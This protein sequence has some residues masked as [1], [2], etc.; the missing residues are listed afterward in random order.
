[1]LDR[2]TWPSASRSGRASQDVNAFKE[3]STLALAREYLERGWS[4]VPQKAGE[5]HP[6]VRWKEF[7]QRLPTDSELAL[8]FGTTWPDAGMAV[9]LGRV[10]NLLVIDV[11][12]EEAHQALLA[13]LGAEP[14]APKTLSGSGQPFRY[15]LFFRHPTGVTTKAKYTPWHPKLE[16]RGERGVVILPPSRHPSGKCYQ[17]VPGRSPADLD[18]AGVPTAVYDA[19]NQ[20]TKEKPVETSDPL[21]ATA[22]T[23]ALDPARAYVMK[24]PPAVEGQNGDKH[25][26]TLACTLVRRFHLA[27]DDALRLMQDWNQQCQPPWTD[28]QL[29]HKIEAADEI[30]GPRGQLL[31][32]LSTVDSTD[33]DPLGNALPA[34]QGLPDFRMIDQ[35]R[36]QLFATIAGL[37]RPF[38]SFSSWPKLRDIQDAKKYQEQAFAEAMKAIADHPG[39]VLA[40]H[41]QQGHWAMLVRNRADLE[42][43]DASGDSVLSFDVLGIPWEGSRWLLGPEANR[44]HAPCTWE[45]DTGIPEEQIVTGLGNIASKLRLRSAAG[46]LWYIHAQVIHQNCNLTWLPDVS[47]ASVVWGAEPKPA[48]WRTVLH[49][50]LVSLTLLRC[51]TCKAN[52]MLQGVPI[53]NNG[54]VL[55][56]EVTDKRERHAECPKACPLYQKNCPHHH[57]VVKAGN[58]FL[59]QLQLFATGNN[60]DGSVSFDFNPSIRAAVASYREV[61]ARH[62]DEDSREFKSSLKSEAAEIKAHHKK[63]FRGIVT[64]PVCI[65]ALGPS[66]GLSG[67]QCQIL[68]ALVRETT[69]ARRK[70]ERPDN[71]DVFSGKHV[72]GTGNGKS[73]ECVLLDPD[74]TYVGFNGN[75]L[76]HGQGY[77]LLTWMTRCGYSV[78]REGKSRRKSIRRFLADLASMPPEFGLVVAGLLKGKWFALPA[79]QSLAETAHGMKALGDMTL[80][81]YAPA[82]YHHQWRAWVA[83]QLSP[84]VPAPRT[85]SGFEIKPA[86]KAAR[87]TQDDLA[88][89]LGKKRTY[90]N[91]LL[92]GKKPWS[93]DLLSSASSYL[94]DPL[95]ILPEM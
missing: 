75:K 86:L 47:L 50:Q 35:S 80:R 56:R 24:V 93:A 22:V 90:I 10:S 42:T 67:S 71:A 23:K 70:G 28:D 14:E 4:I 1:M 92:N 64:A 20:R 53:C 43:T 95:A 84:S 49:R 37:R 77:R 82:T 61:L 33:E 74:G 60:P 26:F 65:Q 2:N 66:A 91:K 7:Q 69:R 68:T 58:G 51:G 85:L 79:L 34:C 11:D 18:I 12:G 55:L 81:F 40:S 63:Q 59:G 3:K 36:A 8:W 9:V 41:G 30:E 54:S 25:T 29:R 88:Q 52:D 16:F 57:F 13:K 73:L 46:L 39:G 62:Y 44:K 6:C 45:P 83:T 5:K 89:F 94:L 48:N 32:A 19:L 15:H 17:W 38:G 31:H 76:R 78:P 87:L 27:P 21:V 72:T